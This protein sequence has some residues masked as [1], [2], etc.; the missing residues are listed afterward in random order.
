M[1]Y[2]G[3]KAKNGESEYRTFK[4]LLYSSPSMIPC[5]IQKISHHDFANKFLIHKEVSL[6][7]LKGRS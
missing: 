2:D 6:F 7:C 4:Y 1:T 3:R 5:N